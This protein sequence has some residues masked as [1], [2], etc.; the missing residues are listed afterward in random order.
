VLRVEAGY[1][2]FY[3]PGRSVPVRVTVTAD[4]LLSGKLVAR[5][6]NRGRATVTR[7]VDVPGGSVKRYEMVI[8]GETLGG[9][10]LEIAV[11]F[12]SL[13][14]TD[15][16]DSADGAELVGLLPGV[17]GG[18]A[19]R[20]VPGAAALSVDVN[21]ARFAALAPD[22]LGRGA[23]AIESLSTIGVT[24]DDLAGL[25]PSARATLFDWVAA[26]GRL[27]L[28]TPGSGKAAEGTENLP[29]AWRPDEGTTRAAAGRGEVR[30]T[31][32]AMTSGRW[33]GLVD[34]SPIS[35]DTSGG[36]FGN[37]GVAEVV[38]RDAGLQLPRLAFLIAF[39]VV[40]VLAVGPVT[41]LVL[42]R[43]RRPELAW[44][45]VPAL[46]LVFTLVAYGVGGRDRNNA[47]IAHGT[48]ID[49]SGPRPVATTW[50]GLTKGGA[51]TARVSFPSGWAVDGDINGGFGF[52]GRQPSSP[53]VALTADGPSAKLELAVGQYG[54]VRAGGPG[55]LPAASGEPGGGLEMTAEADEAGTGV[56]GTVRNRTPW[57]LEEAFVFVGGG[58]EPVG[59]LRPGQKK[60]WSVANLRGGDQDGRD[61]ARSFWG[62]TGGRDSATGPDGVVKLPGWQSVRAELGSEALPPGSATAVG[63]TRRYQ[64]DV[65]VDG[66]RK[67]LEGRTAIL[68]RAPVVAAAGQA[69]GVAVRREV[70][71]GNWPS[72]FGCCPGADDQTVVRFVLP[73]GTDPGRGLTLQGRVRFQT[74]EYWAA[75][76]WQQVGGA[77]AA[78]GGGQVIR[79]FPGGGF[80]V[81]A[82]PVTPTTSIVVAP[83]PPD[84]PVTT[85]TTIPAGVAGPNETVAT[86]APRPAP[87]I[88]PV[89][90][91]PAGGIDASDG[92]SIPAAAAKD[93][94]VFIRLR[95]GDFFEPEPQIMLGVAR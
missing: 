87:A 12:G 30:L 27:L 89:P 88:A 43:R 79:K 50:V 54:I 71:R 8:P 29:A 84:L 67:T 95:F 66:Q 58:V 65:R 78:P 85:V 15:S 64:P 74:L 37:P 11:T 20:A 13:Q 6:G 4:R 26:G 14:A 51:G 52:D 9:G 47:R 63:W 24:P 32:D 46:A 48:L 10:T 93:G 75:G 57:T 55:K 61:W 60:E 76:A 77:V 1:S 16:V 35:R 40:Y 22:D 83:P 28:D 44:V 70:V 34:P 45:V 86:V 73:A 56:R 53:E 42:R 18:G 92:L 39:L 23:A 25:A 5:A 90:F 33:A 72:S 41:A 19:R 38:A 49:T 94:V 31:G 2:G 91:D 21:L 82:V 68:G 80:V 7:S 17:L 36:F 3:V 59:S 62:D 69:P 81:P